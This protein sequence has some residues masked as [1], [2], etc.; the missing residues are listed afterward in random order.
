[1]GDLPTDSIERD[2]RRDFLGGANADFTRLRADPDAWADYQAEI[3]SMDGTLMDGL[4]G[5]RWEE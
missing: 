3:R 2:R 5:D 1:M 4:E